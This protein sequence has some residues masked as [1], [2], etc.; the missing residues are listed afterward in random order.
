MTLSRPTH[1]VL[2]TVIVTCG[3]LAPW[4]LGVV[5]VPERTTVVLPE[6]PPREATFVLIPQQLLEPD[7]IEA[8]LVDTDA[9]PIEELA[10]VQ[11]IDEA[12]SPE[13][14]EPAL[15]ELEAMA[16][17]PGGRDLE[18]AIEGRRRTLTEASLARSRSRSEQRRRKGQRSRA[19]LPD[20]EEIFEVSELSHRVEDELVYHYASH[21]KEAQALAATWWNLD[22][23]GE[24]FGFKLG[25]M[26][27]GSIL[28]QAG[29][30]NGD[31]VTHVNGLEIRSYS[32]GV[33][34]F[35]QLRSKKV[36][37]V[38][39]LRRGEPQRLDFVLVEPGLASADLSEDDP[40]YDPT[41]LVER[42]LELEELPWLQR[43]VGKRRDRREQ[44]R[45]AKAREFSLVES[46]ELVEVDEVLIDPA[47]AGSQ[48]E[49]PRRRRR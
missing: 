41:L 15:A 19:C 28:H 11:E 18:T 20:E 27:C 14:D 44:R 43:R 8:A 12:P 6:P 25:R 23:D 5:R 17:P 48:A 49:R 3:F 42:E 30:R 37:W 10:E 26:R 45:W 24:R 9:E 13:E 32:D 39:V 47:E 7:E 2:A 40:L 21:M 35:M 4:A 22:E 29:F 1:A 33:T 36:L 34:A 46:E 16:G 38:D 31:V